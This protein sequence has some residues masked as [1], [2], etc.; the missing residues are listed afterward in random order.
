M[1]AKNVNLPMEPLAWTWKPG[2]RVSLGSPDIKSRKSR[3][4]S[5]LV[6]AE[7]ADTKKIIRKHHKELYKQI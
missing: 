6:S 1:A 2:L 5:F 7:P 3:K 4:I